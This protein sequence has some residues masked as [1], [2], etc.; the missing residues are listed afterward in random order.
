MPSSIRTV[1]QRIAILEMRAAR[2]WSLAQTAAAFFVTTATI[3]EWLRRI[4]EQG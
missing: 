2:G 3:G 4:D 1:E